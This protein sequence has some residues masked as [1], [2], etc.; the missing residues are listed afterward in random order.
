MNTRLLPV[1]A[2]IPDDDAARAR[3]SAAA[4]KPCAPYRGSTA[5]HCVVCGCKVW[6]GPQQRVMYLHLGRRGQILCLEC[7]AGAHQ[8]AAP[9]VSLSRKEWG[10]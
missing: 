1:F 7:A 6:M 3:L 2:C 5:A 4:G 10:Q 8:P 9:V